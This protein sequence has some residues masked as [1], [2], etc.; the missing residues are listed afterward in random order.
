MDAHRDREGDLGDDRAVAVRRPFELGLRFALALTV[1]FLALPL[2]AIFLRV[3]PVELLA[4]LRDEAAVDALLVSVKTSAHRARVHSR[5]RDA[6]RV[7]PGY[8]AVPRPM[9]VLTLWSCRSSCRRRSRASRCCRRL[10]RTGCW[11]KRWTLSGCPARS[12]AA[13]VLAIIFV[14]SPFYLRQAMA[15]FEAVDPDFTDARGRSA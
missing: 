9:A 3:S 12:Q 5:R 1:A 8:P 13:V 15:A 6:G 10:G 7:V 14:A 2:A 11:A 4:S